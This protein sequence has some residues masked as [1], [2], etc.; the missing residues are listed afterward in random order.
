MFGIYVRFRGGKHIELGLP[1]VY[2]LIHHVFFSWKNRPVRHLA[3]RTR[4]DIL[5]L[6]KPTYAARSVLAT[7]HLC[8]SSTPAN[9]GETTAGSSWDVVLLVPNIRSLQYFFL[10]NLWDSPL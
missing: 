10:A 4:D 9:S 1:R 8:V 7:E 6:L 2:V 3:C 5:E